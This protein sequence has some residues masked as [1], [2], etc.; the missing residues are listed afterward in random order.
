[1]DEIE[2]FKEIQEERAMLLAHLLHHI[3][4]DIQ[5]GEVEEALDSLKRVQRYYRDM[6][7]N[8]S[9]N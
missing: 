9:K 1:M 5:A 2:E 8:R 3:I 7:S 6:V 4:L